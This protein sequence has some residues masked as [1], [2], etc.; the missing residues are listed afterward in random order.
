[1]LAEI[2][3]QDDD[4]LA[5]THDYIQWLFPLAELSRASTNAPLLDGATVEAFKQDEALR[6]HMRAAFVRM[7]AFFGLRVTRQGITK[8]ANWD[9]RKPEWFTTNTH[10]SLRLTRM[11]KSLH[12]LS[13]TWEA[14]ELQRALFDLCA[15]EP[16]CGLDA[17][18]R[19][20]WKDAL[21]GT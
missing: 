20:F 12:A 9:E 11:L 10:N 4:W 18:A 13:F 7:L 19:Q 3:R 8:A 14:A 16:D 17:T 6:N 1:M 21:P 2:L 15:T 5:I